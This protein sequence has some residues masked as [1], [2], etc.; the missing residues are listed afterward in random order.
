M[1]AFNSPHRTG[2]SSPALA[3]GLAFLSLAC[4]VLGFFFLSLFLAPL[5]LLTGYLALQQRV[6]HGH[7]VILARSGIVLGAA[8]LVLYALL[9]VTRA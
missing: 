1:Y 3:T 8:V 4:G 5:A 6:P 7:G 9:L 2:A